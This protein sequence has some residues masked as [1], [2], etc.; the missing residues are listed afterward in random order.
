MR[1][2]ST[3]R[4]WY[5]YSGFIAGESTTVGVGLANTTL[6]RSCM[7]SRPRWFMPGSEP[8]PRPQNPLRDGTFSSSAALP[9]LTSAVRRG[10]RLPVLRAVVGA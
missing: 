5:G 1:K 2:H 8:T 9:D 7:S 3:R 4:R 10:G 6:L